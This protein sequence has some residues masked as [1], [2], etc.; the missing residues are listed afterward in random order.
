MLKGV[1]HHNHILQVALER[2][3][4]QGIAQTTIQDVADHSGSSKANVL[5]HFRNKNHLVDLALAPALEALSSLLERA[6]KSGLDSGESR[7]WF[8]DSFVDFLITHRL[9]THVIVA[10]PYLAEQNDSLGRAHQLMT[11]MAAMVS[12]MTA[13]EEDR[14]RF[15]I[16]VSGATYALVSS[17]I[18]GVPGLNDDALRTALSNVLSQMLLFDQ[19]EAIR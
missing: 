15:G 5:Y 2:F 13:G 4:H 17:G 6:E 19:P 1:S 11:Q 9:A 18:L 3:A 10:H 14:L 8:V 16:A 7:Q 12:A